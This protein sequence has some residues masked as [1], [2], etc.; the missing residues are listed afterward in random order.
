[1]KFLDIFNVPLYIENIDY[2]EFETDIDDS[3]K[4]LYENEDFDR[5]CD[6]I[7]L[8]DFS[9]KM[10]D[11]FLGYIEKY[12]LKK[13]EKKVLESV[14]KYV[15]LVCCDYG[16]IAM[17]C[18]WINI[19][20]SQN[21]VVV[22]KDQYK[23]IEELWPYH[24]HSKY[25]DISGVYYHKSIDDKS[26]NIIFLSPFNLVVEKAFPYGKD[27]KNFET[28]LSEKGKL[29]LFPS[30]LCHRVEPNFSNEDRISLSFDIIIK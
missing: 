9:P 5:L 8:L 4:L 29:V 23:R 12:K 2:G 3:I 14:E 19:L 10:N 17:S 21:D 1:M 30:W 22:E 20:K 7:S 11:N 16:E 27:Y 24:T 28:V 6:G 13:F 15:K 25:N 26:G 18:S